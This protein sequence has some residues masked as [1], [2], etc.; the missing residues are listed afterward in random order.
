MHYACK[1]T[2]Y[3]LLPSNCILDRHL[4][5][6]SDV[7]TFHGISYKPCDS[8]ALY[9]P[10]NCQTVRQ[11]TQQTP[12]RMYGGRATGGQVMR[13]IFHQ[14]EGSGLCLSDDKRSSCWSAL[15]QNTE[16][17]PASGV[18]FFSWLSSL[19]RLQ[20]R[21]SKQ[22]IVIQGSVEYS[23]IITHT[24]LVT[25]GTSKIYSQTALSVL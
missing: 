14:L 12:V 10:E 4:W 9:R 22:T 5:L 25:I 6:V 13:D 8:L 15:E 7:V 23:K 19:I 16:S 24:D 2:G 20:T 18:H 11:H 17:L 21:V 1:S 3:I